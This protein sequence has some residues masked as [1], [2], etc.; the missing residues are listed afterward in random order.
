M[1]VIFA[2]P[3]R[4]YSGHFLCTFTQ[5]IVALKEQGHDVRIIQEY[6]SFVPFA[7]MKCLGLD[8]RRGANQVPFDGQVDYDVIFWIDSDMF[9]IPDQVMDIL[10]DMEI[11][12]EYQ[13]VSGIYKMSDMRHYAC[14]E[15]WDDAAFVRDGSFEFM[16]DESL[17]DRERHIKVAY[18]G[19][20]FFCV[21]KG[22]IENMKYPYFWYPLQEFEREDAAPI[23]DMCSEDVAFCRNLKD[24]GIP[25]MVNTKVRVGHEKMLVI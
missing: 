25:I 2:L 9:F 8:A 11:H 20:G 16:T 13:V 7:R 1:K 22:V 5:T 3:G 19:M 23:R 21:R 6:S 17:S 24:A 10:R 12:P 14:V 15:K 18:N 4:S